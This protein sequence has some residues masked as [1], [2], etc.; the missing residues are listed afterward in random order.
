MFSSLATLR[1]YKNHVADEGP[2]SYHGEAEWSPETEACVRR[3]LTPEP[4]EMSAWL[5]FILD[6]IFI[7]PFFLAKSFK[8]HACPVLITGGFH[9]QMKSSLTIGTGVFPFSSLFLGLSPP[10]PHLPHSIETHVCH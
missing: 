2:G 9:L 8:K 5:V 1:G 7:H 10:P 4:G 3:C 6:N